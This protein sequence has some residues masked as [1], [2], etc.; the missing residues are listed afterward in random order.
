MNPWRRALV[1]TI[2]WYVRSGSPRRGRDRLVSWGRGLLPSEAEAA[3]SLDGRK[4]RL[5]FP[6]DRGWEYLYFAGTFEAGTTQVLG[7]LLRSDDVTFD[8]G[9][10]IGWYTT[11][12]AL[13][14]PRGHC[15][16]F[17]PQPAVF[18]E[19]VANCDLNGLAANVTLN[20]VG[21]GEREGNATIHAFGDGHHGHASLAPVLG[22][23]VRS[24]AC[25][26]TTLDQYRRAHSVERIDFVK[27]DVEGAELMV[28]KGAESV[29]QLDPSPI[30]LLEINVDT[31]RVFGYTPLD[32]LQ[33]L[34]ERDDFRFFR[35]V[36]AWGQLVPM[37]RLEDCAHADNVLCVPPGRWLR[38]G[39]IV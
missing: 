33:F 5:R 39:D 16:A 12:F 29:F 7:R 31:S 19:L 18:N 37:N 20:N 35:I 36:G 23:P 3:P 32:L 9:A 11:F 10:N 28:L 38:M 17:E 27:V 24:T 4:F 22:E 14:A 15:H 25:W 34:A 2:R 13:H 8:I 30:W 26:I 1:E 6:R 21:V